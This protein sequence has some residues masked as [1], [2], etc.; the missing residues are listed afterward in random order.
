LISAVANR[1]P[2]ARVGVEA[3]VSGRHGWPAL[4]ALVLLSQLA[5]CALVR[6]PEQP[7]SVPQPQV[8]IPTPVPVPPV[9][10]TPAPP[11]QAVPVPPPAPPPA[12]R[13]FELGAA[14]TA[15]VADAH[16]QAVS[17]N[18]MLAVSTLERA[19]RIEPANPL[20]WI[21][22]G[23]AHE[24]AGHYEQAGSMGHKALQ[25]ATG[26]PRAQAGAWRLIAESLKARD[27]NDEALEAEKKA[28]LLSPR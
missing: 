2:D 9:T 14:A 22:L 24:T 27:R 23:E 8:A 7:Q 4:A 19:L 5:G 10:V 12:T 26:D 6:E 11:V 15:L 28:D 3:G 25:L 1:H 21:E 20:L 17:G 16:K 18:P 13:H